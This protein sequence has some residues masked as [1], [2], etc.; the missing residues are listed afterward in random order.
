MYVPSRILSNH[1]LE[2]MVDTSDEWITERTGIKERRIAEPHET[3]SMMGAE[4]AKEALKN[5]GLTA[6]AID[7]IICATC[8]PDTVFPSTACHIQRRIGAHRAYGFDLQAA[9]SGFLYGMEIARSLISSGAAN[10]IL[11]VG[12]EKISGIVDWQDRNTCVLFGDGAG[13]AILT[14]GNGRGIASTIIG[15]DGTQNDILYLKSP[16]SNSPF[17]P[18]P[19]PY[20]PACLK[21]EG[22]DVYKKAVTAMNESAVACLERAGVKAQDLACVI[23]HQAN[24]RIIES[25]SQRLKIGLDRFYINLDRY[26]NMS[27]A[28]IPIALHETA[29]QGRIKRGD[30]VLMIA[31][32]GGLTWSSVLIEY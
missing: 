10:T 22:R 19:K 27:A 11:L 31:F 21:M 20:A 12:A 30:W 1:D 14:A 2:K 13:A 6:E 4:A 15:S 24:L 8:T 9:C 29:T 23:P 3:S 32:G 26:G 18:P 25:V 16:P 5:A 28:C 7:V 17:A